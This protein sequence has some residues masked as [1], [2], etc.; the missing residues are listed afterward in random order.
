MAVWLLLSALASAQPASQKP[1]DPAVAVDRL[2]LSVER[3]E[4][5]L[6]HEPVLTFE[7]TRAIFRVE[8]VGRKPRWLPEIDW[9]GY[10]ERI[11]PTPQIPSI[12]DQFLA[13]VTPP[14]ARSFGA[15]EGTDLLQVAITSFLQG[16]ATQAV[17]KKVRDAARKRR[18]EAAKR[19]VDE[20]IAAWLLERQREEA[21]KEQKP[22]P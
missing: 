4:G 16:V 7:S 13:R 21:A 22:G 2:P 3:I 10:Q 19:E 6:Q 12:H 11:G 9:L 20:A 14:E 18:E 1:A 5:G 8:I 15:F 17:T